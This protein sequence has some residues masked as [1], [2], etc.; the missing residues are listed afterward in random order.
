ML[1]LCPRSIGW[2]GAV[3]SSWTHWPSSCQSGVQHHQRRHWSTIFYCSRRVFRGIDYLWFG[4]PQLL[5]NAT[6]G[7]GFHA[8]ASRLSQ[9]VP[10]RS[11]SSDAHSR[12]SC[13]TKKYLSIFFFF[14]FFFNALRRHALRRHAFQRRSPCVSLSRPPGLAFQSLAYGHQY[15]FSNQLLINTTSGYGIHATASRPSQLKVS[16]RLQ[17]PAGLGA[18][19]TTTMPETPIKCHPRS[20]AVQS[21]LQLHSPDQSTTWRGISGAVARDALATCWVELWSATHWPPLFPQAHGR[22]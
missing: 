16:L 10:S 8:T 5:S 3:I 22:S 14:F 12:T 19:G 21:S 15:S 4:Q 11:L 1:E 20:M 2:D 18:G 6:S 9:L 7:Y 13:G 17:N